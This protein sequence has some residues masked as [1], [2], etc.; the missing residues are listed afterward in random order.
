M[1]KVLIVDDD[2]LS[3]ANLKSLLDW[4]KHGFE[5]CG[6][7]SN[8]QIAVNMIDKMIPDIVITDISMPVMDGIEL[9]E[10]IERKYVEIKVIALSGYND[11]DYV[12]QSMKKGAVDYI[13]KHELDSKVLINA[14]EMARYNILSGRSELHRKQQLEIELAS[15]KPILKNNFIKQLI[16]GEIVDKNRIEREVKTLDINMETTNLTIIAV[17]IDDYSFL[18]EKYAA[19]SEIN[20]FTKAFLDICQGVLNDWGKAV[21]SHVEKGKFVIIL[22]LGRV[23]SLLYVYNSINAVIEQIRSSI[24]RYLNITACFGISEICNDIEKIRIYYKDAEE[25]LKV[26]FYQG[27]D[28]ILREKSTGHVDDNFTNLDLND[29]QNIILS[30]KSFDFLKVKEYIDLIF[31]RIINSKMNNKSTQMI[32]IELINI[33]NR[34]ARESAIDINLIYSQNDIP[35]LK[36]Q[37]YD[38]IY[39]I[40][41]WIEDIFEKLINELKSQQIDEIYTDITKKA[42]EYIHANYQ[43]NISL[44]EVAEY[45]GINSSYLSRVFK[46]DCGKGFVEYLNMRRVEKA[47]LLIEMG[48]F[49]LKEIVKEVG[50]SNYNYFFKVFKEILGMTPQEYESS[51]K[52]NVVNV[53]KI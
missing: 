9:I 14:L 20:K 21:I 29:E 41:N 40:K 39:D 8:G 24:K 49:K 46:E 1:L 52:K 7:A 19:I 47:R 30:V 6:E 28:K 53:K 13:L 23:Y 44:N 45:I 36:F 17:E 3:R 37:K 32:V 4:G 43:R 12:R 2:I 35:Y 48:N 42:I 26:K 38:T 11:F 10:Y 5:I 18:E 25:K 50:F 34:I 15:A 27:K 22:S 31:K 51:L 33:V 16:Y